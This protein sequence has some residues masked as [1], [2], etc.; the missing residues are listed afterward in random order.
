MSKKYEWAETQKILKSLGNKRKN[1]QGESLK[2]T[3]GQCHKYIGGPKPTK[4][5][6]A[7]KTISQL[8][9]KRV[10][11]TTDILLG[12]DVSLIFDWD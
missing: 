12:L 11:T 8:Q 7:A 6:I 3:Q 1:K 5:R 9:S 2:Y 10:V 4:I